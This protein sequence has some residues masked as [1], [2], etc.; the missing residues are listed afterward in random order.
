MP[1]WNI[2]ASSFP[3]IDQFNKNSDLMSLFASFFAGLLMNMGP[4]DPAITSCCW[5]AFFTI[6]VLST[7]HATSALN[8]KDCSSV[9]SRHPLLALFKEQF[10]H[11]CWALMSSKG[12][13]F[14][15]NHLRHFF[16]FQILLNISSELIILYS[17]SSRFRFV[18]LLSQWQMI[19]V[20]S[21]INI[22]LI[23]SFS[24]EILISWAG[25]L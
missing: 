4:N 23:M 20:L 12:T 5:L 3:Y 7:D 13:Y 2:S 16:I 21:M 14:H 11:W 22:Y 8:V 1:N 17:I 9:K 25:Q 10:P 24:C 15:F 19:L 6:Q 18:I